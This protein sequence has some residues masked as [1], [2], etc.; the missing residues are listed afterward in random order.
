[1]DFWECTEPTKAYVGKLTYQ[2]LCILVEHTDFSKI[3]HLSRRESDFSDHNYATYWD[4]IA[5]CFKSNWFNQ[6]PKGSFYIF[7]GW[8]NIEGIKPDIKAHEVKIKRYHTQ[9]YAELSFIGGLM[10]D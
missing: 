10:V 2:K 6:I 3:Q 4:D 7:V 8:S 1:V 9:E 5:Q